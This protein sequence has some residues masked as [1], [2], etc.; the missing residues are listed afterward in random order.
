VD[1]TEWELEWKSLDGSSDQE[2]E[3]GVGQIDDT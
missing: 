2:Q 3:H 1:G